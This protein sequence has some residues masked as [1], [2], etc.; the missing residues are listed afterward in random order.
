[1]FLRILFQ[2]SSYEYS[3]AYGKNKTQ[4]LKYN[5]R[6]QIFYT[7]IILVVF[8]FGSLIIGPKIYNFWTQDKYD[9]DYF[10][11]L[12][13]IFDSVF[14][15]LRTSVGN[16]IKAVNKFFKPT[17]TEVFISILMLPSTTG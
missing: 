9:L 2:V 11:L 10:L 3:Q 14:L 13:I 15:N 4:L 16:I 17:I 12:L 5:Y 1:M 8:I 7:F 6:R